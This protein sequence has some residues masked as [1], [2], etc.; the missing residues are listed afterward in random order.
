M[1]T[2]EARQPKL[3]VESHQRFVQARSPQLR[4]PRGGGDPC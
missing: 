3:T 2:S 1:R 4:H